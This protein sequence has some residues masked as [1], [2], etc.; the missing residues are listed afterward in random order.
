MTKRRIIPPDQSRRRPR[1]EEFG[2]L[3]KGDVVKLSREQ[4]EFTFLSAALDGDE[5]VYIDLHGGLKGREMLRSVT[6]DRLKI[7]SDRQLARQRRAR[8]ERQ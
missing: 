2:P 8:A 5:V 7:P 4:G 1:V 3:V 6:P